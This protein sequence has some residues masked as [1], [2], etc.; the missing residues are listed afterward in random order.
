MSNSTQ[1]VYRQGDTHLHHGVQVLAPHWMKTLKGAKLHIY[2]IEHW[3]GH[4]IAFFDS[5]SRDYCICHA[6][7]SL[8]LKVFTVVSRVLLVTVDS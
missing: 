6:R 4:G 1:Q 5:F 8:L 2:F 7:K 3:W